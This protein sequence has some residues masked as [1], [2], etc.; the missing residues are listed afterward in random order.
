[1]F[2]SS[3]SALFRSPPTNQDIIQKLNDIVPL[4]DSHHR[5]RLLV[6][7]SSRITVEHTPLPVP[8]YSN[9]T[10]EEAVRM[11]PSFDVVLDTQPFA[12]STQDPYVLHKTTQRE[13]Y[14]LSRERTGCEWH[15]PGPFDVI[16]WNTQGEI[17][18]TSI[19]NIAIRFIVDGQP[20][21]KTPRV[22]CGVLPGVFRAFLLKSHPNLVED[23][24]TVEDL[25]AAQKVH[26]FQSINVR[27]WD[28]LIL[29]I[30]E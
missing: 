2:S 12:V 23:I 21:W 18:E 14:D 10:L 24:I 7:T 22:S 26:I 20:I 16:L 29:L 6:D 28:P 13:M 3:N 27:E 30:I 9:E 8:E 4:D 11:V 15:G 1:D 25:K 5:I 17:T 19:T